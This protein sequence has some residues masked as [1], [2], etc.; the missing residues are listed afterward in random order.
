MA[1]KDTPAIITTRVAAATAEEEV[2][3]AN[4]GLATPL[5]TVGLTEEVA[6]PVQTAKQKLL[7]IKIAQHFR[8]KWAAALG[9]VLPDIWGP[10][11][12]NNHLRLT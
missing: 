1:I 12:E 11:V 4:I 10:N 8:I 2:V 3:A 7:A 9:I 6:T 5:S